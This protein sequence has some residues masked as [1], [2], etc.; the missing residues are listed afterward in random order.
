VLQDD[1]NLV[2]YE[3]SVPFWATGILGGAGAIPPAGYIDRASSLDDAI[4]GVG[5]LPAIITGSSDLGQPSTTTVDAGGVAY[6]VTEQRRKIVNEIVEQAFLQDIAAM[7]VWPGQVIQG[8]PL[9]SGDVAP[10]GPLPRSGGTINVVTDLITVGAEGLISGTPVD[11]SATL[12]AP[13]ATSVDQA[14]RSIIAK[15]NPTDSPGI[16]K[17]GIDKASTFRELGVK[18]GLD[19]KG[20]NF[21]VDANAA[22]NQTYK[23]STSVAVIRQIFYSVTFTPSGPR[24]EGFWTSGTKFSNLAPYIG[25][26]NPPLFIDSVQFGRLICVTAQGS[27]SSSDLTAALKASVQ[28]NVNAT[29]TVDLKTKEVLESSQMK[30]YTIGVPGARNVQ[31]LADPVADLQQVY[32]SGLTF[33]SRNLGAPVSF[34]A[35]HIADGTLARVALSAEYIAPLSAVGVDVPET[36]F[37]VWDGAGGGLRDTGVQVNPGDT[38]TVSTTGMIWSGVFLSGTHGPQ[39]WPGHGADNAAPLPSGTAYCLVLSFGGAA[40]SWIEGGPFWQGKPPS[41]SKGGRLLLN[42]NDNNPFNGNPSD[43]WTS[44]VSVKRAGAGAAG[45]FI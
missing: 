11:Q 10:I 41:T 43:R 44:T 6:L 28:S 27:Y 31:T 23:Q 38:V 34:T 37:Q 9:L 4:D 1:G 40:G 24:S 21:G 20:S 26:G 12:E 15:T 36:E 29:G 30:V 35:R 8:R 32:R 42:I 2:I 16:L 3:G 45:V 13:D 7:G 39:G 14:R 25:P 18:V 19:I 22:L 33:N 17:I 5:R